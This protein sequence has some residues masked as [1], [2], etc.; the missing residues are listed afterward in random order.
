MPFADL[1]YL[2]IKSEFI[3]YV[4]DDYPLRLIALDTLHPG[5]AGGILCEER[6][7]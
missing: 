6:L 7:E 5:K 1:N 3:H 2:P 4:V